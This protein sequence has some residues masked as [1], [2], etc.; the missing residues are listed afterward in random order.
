[1]ARRQCVEDLAG[2]A[3]HLRLD[4][5]WRSLMASDHEAV[6][7][8]LDPFRYREILNAPEAMEDGSIS[9]GASGVEWRG[10]PIEVVRALLP[11]PATVAHADI[12]P[13]ALVE[14]P[15]CISLHAKKSN[16]RMVYYDDR[17][18]HEA[19]T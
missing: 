18:T 2:L 1:M 3:Y 8:Q 6:K 7:I 9:Y 15:F 16:G 13:T 4:I 12:E 11:C 17:E 5:L 14:E 10:I 19:Y